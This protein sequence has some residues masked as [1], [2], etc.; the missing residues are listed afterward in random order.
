[1]F[2][3]DLYDLTQSLSGALFS[4]MRAIRTQEQTDPLPDLYRLRAGYAESPGWFM[5][6]AL[7]FDPQPLTVA[8]LRVRDIYASESLVAALL[9]IMASEKW[10]N[11]QG[12]NYFL[13]ATGRA[14]ARE[15]R[16]G[17]N[18]LLSA[19]QP[20]PQVELQR[21]ENG[22]ARIIKAS[23][24]SPNPPGT[25]CLAHSRRRAPAENPQP[26]VQIYQYTAD[27]NA[28]RDDAHMA[29]WQPLGIDGRTWEAFSFVHGGAAQSAADLF[30]Q[31][32]Y[33][34][35]SEED[36]AAALVGL[37]EK[38]WIKREREDGAGTSYQVT[39]EGHLVHAG[40]ER[41]TDD[42]FFTPWHTL[43]QEE[44]AELIQLMEQAR[45]ALLVMG[46]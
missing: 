12:K 39:Q 26:A 3:A 32:A 8:N 41:L 4:A 21:L 37:E 40:V 30:D 24:Q 22:L 14:L 11:R 29:A 7:E 6:Q 2:N 17:I 9:E 13:S 43:S 28:F 31:L 19:L 10:L 18:R 27:F 35:Y 23:L 1:M 33:R 34:G 20:L 16:E 15:R 42:Y 38:S 45:D 44:I 25:W 5:V 36:Y 46:G